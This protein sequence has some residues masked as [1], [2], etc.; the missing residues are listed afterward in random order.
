VSLTR[1]GSR[2]RPTTNLL[3]TSRETIGRGRGRILAGLG[4]C[5][6]PVLIVCTA[7]APAFAHATVVSTNP[8]ADRSVPTSPATV[9]L[10]FNEDVTIGTTPVTLLDSA[11]N[12]EPLGRARLSPDAIALTVAVKT[13]LPS[14]VYTV[15][16]QV[17]SNDGDVVGGRYAFGVGPNVAGQVTGQAGQQLSNPGLWPTSL[18]RWLLFG[19][20]A[21]GFGGIASSRLVRRHATAAPSPAPV[22]WIL[23]AAVT[24]MAAS[25]GLAVLNVGGGDLLSGLTHPSVAQLIQG[26][27]GRLVGIE[28]LAFAA[29]AVSASLRRPAYAAAALF[30]VAVA[31]GLRGHPGA[32]V[33]GWGVLLVTAHF[34]VAAVWVGGLIHVLR[35]VAAWRGHRH[36]VWSVLRD[37]SKWA[38]L[39]FVVV[40]ASGM[41]AALVVTPLA[42]ISNTAYGRTLLVKLAL[43]TAAAGIAYAARRRLRRE[44]AVAAVVS[45]ARVES[46][47]LVAVLAVTGLLVSLP[48]PRVPAGVPAFAP[49][50][51]GPLVAVGGRAGQVGV[52][53][54]AAGDRVNITLSAPELG[55]GD[56]QPGEGQSYRLSGALQP[57]HGRRQPLELTGCGTGCFTAPTELAAGLNQLSLDVQATGW[58]GG[59]IALTVPWPP[60]PAPMLLTRVVATMRHVPSFTLSE[61]VTSD[62]SRGLGQPRRITVTGNHFIASEPYAQAR[63]SLTASYTTPA[64]KVLDLAYPT[65]AI[66]IQLTL[67]P[68]NQIVRET[69]ATPDELVTR[70]FIYPGTR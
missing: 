36:L 33:G 44:A 20:F 58:T 21:I 1:P 52:L 54:Q 59:P 34:A 24:G 60:H 67:D 45:R 6:V 40:A 23:P 66:S 35:A 26:R 28:L 5:L 68:N 38:L 69:L 37:Y 61:Q 70:S 11:G 31:E 17:T 62:G 2:L 3:P 19:G 48:R 22:P 41:T 63:A 53:V 13:R 51:N 32:L 18:L 65:D 10:S 50:L 43:V 57:S 47:V 64:G 12:T 27:E 49:P 39:L 4:C 46:M 25:V 14:G 42:S 16:W 29:A 7:G 55:S 30:I 8:T 56:D 9:S 15:T